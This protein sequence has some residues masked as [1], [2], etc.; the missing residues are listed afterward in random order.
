VLKTARVREQEMNR[1]HKLAFLAM[2]LL[3]INVATWFITGVNQ[4]NGVYPVDA[5]SIGIPIVGTLFASLV[6]LPLL[7]LIGLLPTA[8][9]VRRLCS[10][11]FRWSIAAGAA[12]LVLYVT[13]G[14]FAVS[15]VAEWA[16]PHHYLIAACYSFLLLVLVAFL[17]L[18]MKRLFSLRM[19]TLVQIQLDSDCEK[20]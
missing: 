6:V 16:I 18:D 13:V 2:A 19:G 10:R 15:G 20:K 8:G 14:L 7:L 17:F 11:G 1:W 9:F 12:L 5:D 4:R 3:L